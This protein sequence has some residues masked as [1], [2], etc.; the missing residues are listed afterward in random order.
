[1]KQIKRKLKSNIWE[2]RKKLVSGKQGRENSKMK[3]T[4]AL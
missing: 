4:K 3:V 1:M 2:R